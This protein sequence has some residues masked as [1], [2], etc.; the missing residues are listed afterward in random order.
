MDWASPN[1]FEDVHHD[2]RHVLFPTGYESRYTK[3]DLAPLME[4]VERF[5]V[6][7]HVLHALQDRAMTGDESINREQLKR[8]FVE[9]PNVT[10]VQRT[11]PNVTSAVYDYVGE[12]RI[13]LVA[14]MNSKHSFLERLLVKQKVDVIG[15]HSKVPFLV[16][17]EP[18]K[19][20][21]ITP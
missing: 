8:L 4:L 10:Y 9:V 17:P 11:T 16:I 19:S 15:Y 5:G 2:I 20:V 3:R 18:I 12:N 14:M 1:S 7:L 6:D 13:D 21:R